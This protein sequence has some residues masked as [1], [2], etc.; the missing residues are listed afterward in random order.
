MAIDLGTIASGLAASGA[1]FPINKLL[2]TMEAAG[3][4]HSMWKIAGSPNRDGGVAGANP[5]AF[6]AGSGYIPTRATAGAIGQVNPTNSKFV[7]LLDCKSLVAGTLILFDR[8]W[9]CSAILSN[10]TGTQT[11]TTPGTLTAG[12]DPLSGLDV[13]PWIEYYTTDGATGGVWTLTGTDS[14]G[15]ASRTWTATKPASAQLA[16]TIIPMLNGSAVGGCRVPTSMALSVSSGTA[17]DCGVTLVRRLAQ[18]TV[19]TVNV[20]AA[21]DA[22]MLGLPEVF[23]DACLFFVWHNTTTTGQQIQ[24]NVGLPELTP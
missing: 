1:R 4:Y 5:P 19:A 24:G 20:E 3:Q 7:G 21:K 18:V 23:D 10:T 11:I 6:T 22:I 16:G 12:R 17:G 14:S 2:P 15:T 8:L 13:E 9:A